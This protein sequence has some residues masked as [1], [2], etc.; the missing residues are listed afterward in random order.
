M[1]REIAPA[2]LTVGLGVSGIPAGFRGRGL[3]GREAVCPKGDEGEAPPI[4]PLDPNVSAELVGYGRGGTLDAVED[5][6][7]SFPLGAVELLCS[8]A[9]TLPIPAAERSSWQQ[10]FGPVKRRHET[11]E[12]WAGGSLPNRPQSSGV[13]VPPTMMVLSS[14]LWLRSCRL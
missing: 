11:R 9:C 13:Y 4:V 5:G 1:G 14:R 10:V 7:D 12:R 8:H 3:A 6:L 2:A